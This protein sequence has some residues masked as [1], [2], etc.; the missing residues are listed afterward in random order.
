MIEGQWK[1]KRRQG[2]RKTMERQKMKC[3]WIE[4]ERIETRGRC[5]DMKYR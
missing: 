5:S 1:G 2:G 3:W 4:D